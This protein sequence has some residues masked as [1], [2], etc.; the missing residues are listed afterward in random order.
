MTTGGVAPK[1]TSGARTRSPGL[2][3][4]V[5]CA[6]ETG[7]GARRHRRSRIRGSRRRLAVEEPGRKSEQQHVMPA[8]GVAGSRLPPADRLRILKEVDA[9]KRPGEVG[10]LLRREGLYSS[11]L[12]NWRRQRAGGRRVE[13]RWTTTHGKSTRPTPTPNTS[14]ITSCGRSAPANRRPR[15][16][17]ARW[18][19][20]TRPRAVRRSAPRRR[21]D[22]WTRA[23]PCPWVPTLD[24]ARM[25]V[26]PRGILS[27]DERGDRALVTR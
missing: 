2:R 14:P 5:P 10:A 8:G 12:T 1:A 21:C 4:P 9:C 11:L 18:R 20:N 16:S 23:R 24:L 7:A 3:L 22:R 6:G 19:R 15:N 26:H 13:R 25:I 17:S 27:P